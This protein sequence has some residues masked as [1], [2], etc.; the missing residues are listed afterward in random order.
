MSSM[1]SSPA[2]P[3][4]QLLN[5]DDAPHSAS[6]DL[7]AD[8]LGLSV[9]GRIALPLCPAQMTKL[10]AEGRP[11]YVGLGEETLLDPSVRDTFEIS[12][13]QVHLEGGLW[14]RSL[15]AALKN[16]GETLGV[17]SPENLRAELHSMLIYGAGQFFAPHQDSEKHDDMVATLV[18]SLPSA[19]TGGELVIDDNGTLT[20]YPASREDLTLVAFYA[21]RRHE[22]RPVRSGTRI[23]LTFNV[24]LRASTQPQATHSID[25]AAALIEEHFTQE[26]TYYGRPLNAP[27]ALAFLLDHEYSQHGLTSQRLKGADAGNVA[28]LSAAARA[29]ECEW[30][31]ALTDINEVR[32]AEESYDDGG[33]YDGD[34]YFDDNDDDLSD[35]DESDYGIGEIID[36]SVIAVWWND[37]ESHGDIHFAFGPGEVSAATPTFEHTPYSSEYEGYMGNYG[38][39]VDRWYRRAAFVMWPAQQGFSVRAAASTSWALRTIVNSIEDGELDRARTQT[40]AYLD[41]GAD[42]TEQ[43]L[44]SALEIARGVGKSELAAAIL[45]S[46]QVEMLTPASATALAALA[47]AYDGDFWAA[48]RAS[49]DQRKSSA[50]WNR[51]MWVQEALLPLVRALQEVDADAVGEWLAEWMW[52]WVRETYRALLTEENVTRRTA[53]LTDLGP[54]LAAILAATSEQRRKGVCEILAGENERAL[55]LLL[56]TLISDAVPHFPPVD[57]VA[58]AAKAQLEGMLAE[59][60]RAENDWAIPWVSPGGED[61]DR[62]AA[63]LNSHDRILE[64]PLAAPRRRRIHSAIDHAGLPVTHRTRRKGSPFVLVLTKT[65]ELFKREKRARHQ[66]QHDLERLSSI[67]PS[68]Q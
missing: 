20:S 31:L 2:Q 44:P 60:V 37:A 27:T 23:T 22:V 59:P 7:A 30:A 5:A 43:S 9:D 63:F 11:A 50:R 34:Y 40:I 56:G 17:P 1:S 67:F 19:H 10:R 38:N 39:T 53:R 21:D 66:A 8:V 6:I 62:L 28:I 65:P 4:A 14:S 45:A 47:P 46:A 55:P 54:T 33:F 16:L 49:W 18:V 68:A 58:A 61:F 36:D 24:L 15:A 35:V 12:P 3:L 25:G 52:E 32:H 42:L 57:T 13:H 26:R 64:W 51:P 29:T 41:V 48:L